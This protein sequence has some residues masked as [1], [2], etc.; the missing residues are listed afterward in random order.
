MPM[1][2]IL[3]LALAP[4]V[5]RILARAWLGWLSFACTL[6]AGAGWCS[7]AGGLQGADLDDRYDRRARAG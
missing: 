1:L 3:A 7:P 2:P 6:A 5:E 4:T